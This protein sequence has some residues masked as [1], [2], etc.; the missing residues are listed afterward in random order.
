MK[1]LS[2]AKGTDFIVLNLT[3]IQLSNEEW[4]E[5]HK[6][7]KIL[8][9][10]V[11]DLVERVKPDLITLS[12][13]IS[14]AGHDFAYDMLAD[15]LDSFKIPWAPVWGNHDNQNGPECIER[16]VE[17]YMKHAYCVYEKGDPAIGN[18]NYVIAVEEEGR[19]VE[20]IFMMD[21][22]DRETYT[23]ADG[24]EKKA[25]AKLT[26]PQLEWY[27]E[28]NRLLKGKGCN[29]TTIIMHIPF[30]AYRAA[31][32]AAYAEGVDLKNLTVKESEGTA[33]WKVGYQDSYGVQY[34]GIGSYVA[35]DGVFDVVK[36]E[37]TTKHVVVG[38]DHVNNWIIRYEGVNLVYGLKVGAGCYWT[39]E[40]NGGTV[41]RISEDGVRQV[42][43]EY[44][45]VK[46]FLTE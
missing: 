36:Q 23:D 7:R 11:K 14:W 40:L 31:S 34:E 2:K 46:M 28:Q 8:E 33:C 4:E 43:H 3:D 26:A 13:D 37:G 1:T 6:N 44:V 15:F 42:Y 9:H 38:H 29:D 32:Q 39:P 18:G 27:R 22:H 12:G 30:Y 25:W 17:R 35:E 10:T 5:G 20:G 16:V 24:E 21:S 19:V 45:D 41:I